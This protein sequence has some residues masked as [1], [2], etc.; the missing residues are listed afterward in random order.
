MTKQ[1][2]SLIQP[3]ILAAGSSSRFGR[4]KMCLELEGKPLFTHSLNTFLN[5]LPRQPLLVCAEGRQQEFAELCLQHC[6][7][8]KGDIIS[9]GSERFLSVDKALEHLKKKED[10]QLWVAIH[11]AARPF[12]SEKLIVECSLIALKS[13]GSIIAR[14]VTDTIKQMSEQGQISTPDRSQ[15][16]SA[17]TPQIFPLEELKNSI[18]HCIKEKWHITDDASAMELCG[19]TYQPCLH[20]GDNRKITFAS[21]LP[22]I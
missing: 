6:P 5:S 17:E 16:L 12:I 22:E 13:G 8:F 2:L 20:Q 15:L 10:E 1:D 19:Y 3:I 9:G 18:A 4:D 14:P 7:Q 11:D 21:D